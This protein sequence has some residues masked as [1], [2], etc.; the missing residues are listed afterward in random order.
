M[1]VQRQIPQLTFK[2]MP[3]TRFEP[4]TQ[5][6]VS[7]HPTTKLS[8]P[9]STVLYRYRDQTKQLYSAQTLK[10]RAKKHMYRALFGNGIKVRF[11]HAQL[12]MRVK[13]IARILFSYLGKE[14]EQ[15]KGVKDET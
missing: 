4:A 11:W 15:K 9:R 6:T 5:G 3:S 12:L 1:P 10:K 8:P 14:L 13:H 2:D 7:G